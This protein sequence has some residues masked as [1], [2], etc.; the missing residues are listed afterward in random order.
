MSVVHFAD[1]EFFFIRGKHQSINIYPDS[2]RG[3]Y[4]VSVTEYTGGSP[5]NYQIYPLG[6][7][8][9]VEPFID[10]SKLQ[11]INDPLENWSIVTHEQSLRNSVIITTITFLVTIVSAALVAGKLL[12]KVKAGHWGHYLTIAVTARMIYF[13]FE[14]KIVPAKFAIANRIFSVYNL[15]N[16]DITTITSETKL[17]FLDQLD[18]MQTVGFINFQK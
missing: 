2:H 4:L 15:C 5:T 7:K 10:R 17:A 1:L 3:G 12:G 9:I 13:H 6:Q 11:V 14:N 8:W 16:S 18:K